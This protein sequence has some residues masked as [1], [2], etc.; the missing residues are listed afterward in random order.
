MVTVDSGGASDGYPWVC[1][2]GTHTHEHGYGFHVGV[3]AG[4]PKNTHELPVTSTKYITNIR[5]DSE[6][7]SNTFFW[8][9]YLPLNAAAFS[10]SSIYT[11]LGS[12]GIERDLQ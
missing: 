5:Q 2:H 10:S 6:S 8:Q 7:Q 12:Y 1:S 11:I 9:Y 3:G 4:G